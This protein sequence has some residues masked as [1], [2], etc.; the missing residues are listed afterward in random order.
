MRRKRKGKK[1]PRTLTFGDRMILRTL[2]LN[3]LFLG[4]LLY[5]FPDTAFTAI[6]GRGDWMLEGREGEDVERARAAIFTTADALEW[7]HFQNLLSEVL[8]VLVGQLYAISS[9]NASD[10][11]LLAVAGP[12]DFANTFASQVAA[13]Y[14]LNLDNHGD[15]LLVAELVEHESV[16][17][18][19][20]FSAAAVGLAHLLIINFFSDSAPLS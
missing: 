6:S 2:T 16:L 8:N 7:L 3:L 14:L 11:P 15:A 19:V 12:C 1:G 9:L 10:E 4:P 20:C 5:R 17:G 13:E 18:I